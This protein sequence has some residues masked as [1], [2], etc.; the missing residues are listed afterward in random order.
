MRY[1]VATITE[2]S[3]GN[4]LAVEAG[5]KRIVIF[6]DHSGNFSALENRCSHADVRLSEGAFEDGV[7]EC[8]AHGA[9]FDVRSGKPLCMPAVSPVKRFEVSLEGEDVFV[10][11]P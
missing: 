4:M 6:R 9:R 8:P 11:V 1:K 10:T 5:E 7:V 2:I 3:P